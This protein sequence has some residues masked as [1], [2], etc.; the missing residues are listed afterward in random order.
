VNR[1]IYTG[2]CGF[3]GPPRCLLS[4]TDNY[5]EDLDRYAS[6][7]V[8]LGFDS[9]VW[10]E[11]TNLVSDDFVE[12]KPFKRFYLA[13]HLPLCG[14]TKIKFF[15]RGKREIVFTI[16]VEIPNVFESNFTFATSG[17]PDLVFKQTY[18]DF[19]GLKD[20]NQEFM[21]KEILEMRNLV[22]HAEKSFNTYR[23]S[24]IEIDLALLRGQ[25]VSDYLC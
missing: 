12:E 2:L 3:K 10:I 13:G 11:N 14:Q 15:H 20:F 8:S 17:R 5:P 6:F 22:R 23:N 19:P 24:T 21:K 9:C 7:F 4:E 1:I 25:N 18:L 16:K